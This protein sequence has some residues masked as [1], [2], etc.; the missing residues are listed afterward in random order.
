MFF[1]FVLFHRVQHFA[2][3]LYCNTLLCLHVALR[4]IVGRRTNSCQT[5]TS[6]GSGKPP[7]TV[8]SRGFQRPAPYGSFI[9]SPAGLLKSKLH[10]KLW[11]VLNVFVCVLYFLL[12]CTRMCALVAPATQT[13]ISLG[14][15]KSRTFL[16]F[17]SFKSL[18]V[19]IIVCKVLLVSER[20]NLDILKCFFFIYFNNY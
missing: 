4:C 7:P 12:T 1:S 14:A 6:A 20:D 15:F 13:F 10:Q 11:S 5:L 17:Y 16:L 2:T 19:V 3:L 9:S 8:I 18:T